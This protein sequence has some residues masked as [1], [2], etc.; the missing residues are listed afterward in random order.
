M[1]VVRIRSG[2]EQTSGVLIM[3]IEKYMS[4]R[5]ALSVTGRRSCRKLEQG[6]PFALLRSVP[7]SSFSDILLPLPA[8][9]VL[10]EDVELRTLN[11]DG[12]TKRQPRTRGYRSMHWERI[13]TTNEWDVVDTFC[14][15][16]VRIRIPF[17]MLMFITMGHWT[18]IK[19]ALPE[20]SDSIQVKFSRLFNGDKIWGDYKFVVDLRRKIGTL[21]Y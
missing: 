17:M 7:P 6:I 18:W 3:S 5:S 10:W 13:R 16:G 8:G 21:S 2:L 19:Q 1:S 9:W 4:A 14:Y 20:T 15:Q 11:L 12:A